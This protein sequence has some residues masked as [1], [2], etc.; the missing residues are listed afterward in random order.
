MQELSE[1]DSTQYN[2]PPPKSFAIWHLDPDKYDINADA[3]GGTLYPCH[4]SPPMVAPNKNKRCWAAQDMSEDIFFVDANDD[5]NHFAM[6]KVQH[7]SEATNKFTGPG[8]VE[9]PDGGIW[10]CLIAAD[11][12]LVR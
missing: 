3:N 9:A 6:L 1:L 8:I 7:P 12:S 11:A 5:G 10:C 4:N 2:C